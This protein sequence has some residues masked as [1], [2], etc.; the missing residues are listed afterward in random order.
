MDNPL[1]AMVMLTATTGSWFSHLSD[2]K[3]G[4]VALLAA[5]AL[6]FA[7]GTTTV[8]QIGLPSRIDTLE[9][10]VT[11]ESGLARRVEILEEEHREAEVERD[12]ILRAIEW[13]GCAIE[14][15]HDGED[16]RVVCG[17]RPQYRP[18]G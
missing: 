12:Y 17:T 2:T 7:V 18:R 8:S 4:V 13:Q 14:A 15:Q 16:M 1:T 3:K 10:A 6:G 5:I 11:G 9:A